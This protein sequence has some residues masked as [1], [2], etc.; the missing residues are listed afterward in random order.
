M[1]ICP[2]F[3][4]LVPLPSCVGRRSVYAP[5]SLSCTSVVGG[6]AGIRVG[7]WFFSRP[8]RLCLPT[9]PQAAILRRSGVLYGG[10]GQ[11]HG[12]MM[13]TIIAF[14]NIYLIFHWHLGQLKSRLSQATLYIVGRFDAL[15]FSS[16]ISPPPP[17]GK[18]IG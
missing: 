5:C 12:Y 2:S 18:Y 4:P 6:D 11:A 15:T 8:L 1:K 10:L 14:A 3:L 9:P 17:V 13:L 16:I 7:L